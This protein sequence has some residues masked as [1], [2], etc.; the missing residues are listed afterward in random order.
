M[1]SLLLICIPTLNINL[2][3]VLLVSHSRNILI[4]SARME[5][6]IK[7]DS[8]K[9]ENGIVSLD[10]EA[11]VSLLNILNKIFWGWELFKPSERFYH[12]SEPRRLHN[13]PSFSF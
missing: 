6:K 4:I 2:G 5:S 12:Q 3:S 7:N 13:K 1:L 11:N 10:G 8:R 9:T